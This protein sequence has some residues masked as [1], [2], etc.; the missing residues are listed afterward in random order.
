MKVVLRKNSYK[1]TKLRNKNKITLEKH[2][3][4][5]SII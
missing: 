4:G 3:S 1:R 5:N 2:K